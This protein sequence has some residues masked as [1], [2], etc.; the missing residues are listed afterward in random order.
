MGDGEG[1]APRP[2]S[3]LPRPR[4]PLSSVIPL[5][6]RHRGFKNNR[7]GGG[8][9]AMTGSRSAVFSCCRMACSLSLS[10]R[11]A[12]VVSA[13][14]A[15]APSRRLPPPSLPPPPPPRSPSP[16]LQQGPERETPCAGTRGGGGGERE[17]GASH[18]H[19]VNGAISFRALREKS[20]ST[21]PS[22]RGPEWLR[23]PLQ[24]TS[25]SGVRGIPWEE[26][27]IRGD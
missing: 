23:H 17:E 1:R 5:T 18:C 21:F 13:P 14:A 24:S 22:P 9:A 25:R 20:S 15:L 6:S 26:G 10:T 3:R 7:H 12:W 8:N 11:R 16:A 4:K 27:S 2:S 19:A